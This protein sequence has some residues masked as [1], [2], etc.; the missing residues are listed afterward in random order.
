MKEFLAPFGRLKLWPAFGAIAAAV[1]FW[2]VA[3]V[4][5]VDFALWQLVLLALAALVAG[6]MISGMRADTEPNPDLVVRTVN[7]PSWRPFAEVN[8]WE[9]RFVFAEAKPGRF[10]TSNAK[11][12]IEE[13]AA[14]RLRLRRG[15]TLA[16]DPE[17][18]RALLGEATFHFLTR[19]VPDCPSPRELAEHLKTIEEI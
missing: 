17:A 19:P 13:V 11:A 5:G 15:L 1:F 7:E 16:A 8:R 10:G 18:C 2:S 9:D 4:S 14:E 3:L 12:Q 6:S